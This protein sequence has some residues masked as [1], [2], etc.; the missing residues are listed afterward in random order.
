MKILI[1]ILFSLKLLLFHAIMLLKA[2]AVELGLLVES[3]IASIFS[4]STMYSIIDNS[5]S[6]ERL[7]C[8]SIK[9]ITL[10]INGILNKLD[11][12]A[13]ARTDGEG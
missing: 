8:M 6:S 10:Q 9:I 3:E 11:D 2:L 1:L 13:S 12:W 4:D 5:C 7:D